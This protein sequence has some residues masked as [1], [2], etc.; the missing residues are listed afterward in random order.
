MNQENT[1]AS[2][3]PSS[4]DSGGFTS[5]FVRRPVLALVLNSLII[6][7]GIAALFAVDVRELPSI[8]SPVLTVRTTLTGAAP[9][10][11]DQQVTAVIEGAVAR[12]TGLTNLSSSSSFGS[13]RVRLEFSDKT[14]ITVAS[15]DVRDAISRVL[16]T[17][18]D[19]AEEPVIIKS[20]PDS[21]PIIRLAVTSDTSSLEQ[22]TQL[23]EDSI[24]D[25]LA[26]VDGVADV[27][28]YGEQTEIFRVDINQMKLARYGLTPSDLVASINAANSEL[29]AGSLT[30]SS[31]DILV[32]ASTSSLTAEALENVIIAKNVR[33]ADVATVS[34][35]PDIAST[36]LRSN[37]KTGI[38]LGII[39]Q[40]QSNTLSI[41]NGVHAV[42]EK[43]KTSLPPGTELRITSD[44][45]TFISAS[46]H[47]VVSSLVLA[48][49]IVVAII[50]LFLGSLR[51]TLI[52]A[53]TIPVALIGTL[54]AIYMVGFSVNI[55][56][57]LAIV[58][59]TGMVVDDAIVVLENIMRRRAG[60]MGRKAAAVIGTKQVFFA[61]IATTATLAAVFVPISFMPGQ[62]GGLFKEFGFVLAFSVTLSSLVALTLC[63]ML[64]S[65]ILPPNDTKVP[66][67]TKLMTPVGHM[68]SNIYRKTLG[69]CI[70]APAVVITVSLLICLAAAGGFASL[71]QELVPTEDRASVLLRISTAQGASLDFTRD[72]ILKVE[73]HL[74]PF[75][76]SGEIEN[77]Y[78]IVGNG[79][80]NSG[81]MVLTLAPWDKRIRSQSAIVD[82][83]NASLD[84]IPAIRAVALQPN[85]LGIRGSGNGLQIA[86]LGYDYNILQQT[87]LNI[88]DALDK[89]GSFQNVRLNAEPNQPQ[90]SLSID[91]VR[92]SDL[93]INT[94][95]LAVA[96]QSMLDGRKIGEIF[97]D[98]RSLP[99]KLLSTTTPVND[100]SDLEHL[101]VK[102][103]NGTMLPLS[104]IATITEEA[105]TPSLDRESQMRA[106]SLSAGLNDGVTL[107][108]ALDIANEVAT[109]LLPP[110]Y[111]MIPIGE[112]AALGSNTGGLAQT[113]AFALIIIFLVL[114]AQ[115][116]SFVSAV[117]IMTT[118][119][120]GLACAIFAMLATGGTLNVYSQI[121]LVML[122][123][124]MAKN[125]ILIVEFANQLRDEGQSVREAIVNAS[126]QRLR[127]VAM[128]MIATILGGV[129]LVLAHGAGAE[130]RIALG[131]VVVGGLGL[132][133]LVTLY[134]TPV[135]YLLLARFSKPHAQ[136]AGALQQ[137]LAH[138]HGIQTS[139]E[140]AE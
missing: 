126:A 89:T 67:L 74:A 8:S 36:T 92:A 31:Q 96:M 63:P 138:A 27:E 44:D 107:G 72:Q 56:T 100:P 23:V 114:A 95:G 13:S 71:K 103:A 99:V 20:D 50:Y 109:P 101:F 97:V 121:G 40:A 65:Q 62:T 57:L 26:A 25:P 10:T 53:I 61:V 137:E 120:L 94:T 5:T 98:G 32:R 83:M 140:P 69:I 16:N 1:P 34:L 35:G 87:A 119:P 113:F 37:G 76:D 54:A 29:P 70:N 68:F 133:T 4:H 52:P 110:S 64:A 77:M 82:D 139:A 9:E 22:L 33:L 42:V 47:E 73:E 90:L 108:A 24:I 80:S 12:V 105:V 48:I 51:A 49:V 106:V 59:A 93:G 6:V 60:G 45:A 116:E 102:G 111:R 130:S 30:S 41:S 84:S 78:S 85:S 115:F 38:G 19:G 129:P 136:K 75:I 135:A 3:G 124:I 118:V 17:L 18:P 66:M 14:N 125:G 86:V 55:L 11:V 7:A 91:P 2:P 43:L 21:Q 122:V 132:A 117:V 127:P 128:T 39:R 46:L 58:L 123:G 131:W 79:A 104:T 88:R 28:T 112:A 134:I 81:I 15:S